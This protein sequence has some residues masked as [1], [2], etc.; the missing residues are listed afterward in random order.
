VTHTPRKAL[1]LILP[2]ADP[3]ERARVSKLVDDRMT[4]GVHLVVETMAPAY[5][6]GDMA[7]VR[8]LPVA[9]LAPGQERHAKDRRCRTADA[10]CTAARVPARALLRAESVSAC[11]DGSMVGLA[12]PPSGSVEK[13]GQRC[14]SSA[15]CYGDPALERDWIR[16]RTD[17]M[18]E[19]QN[20][21]ASEGGNSDGAPLPDITP[22]MIEA[23]IDALAYG[24][25]RFERSD[26]IVSRI[27]REMTRVMRRA[28]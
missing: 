8:T 28:L 13:C 21:Q 10:V 19:H 9:A 14:V 18:N 27:F 7:L 25:P 4:A 2:L 11:H 1:G 23:G 16:E 12:R 5:N 17:H 15:S 22:E 20:R 24:D 26:I 3:V 6:K